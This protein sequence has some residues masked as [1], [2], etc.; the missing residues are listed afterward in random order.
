MELKNIFM[1]LFLALTLSLMG[2][3]AMASESIYIISHAGAGDPFWKVEFKGARAAANETGATLTI[4]APETPNDIA[5]E[6]ELLNS[7]IRTRPAGIAVTIPDADKFSDALKSARNKGIP[8][9][10][11]NVRPD[12]N[13]RVKNP[14]LAYIGMEEYLAGK[15]AG[16]HAFLSGKINKRVVVINHQTGHMGLEAR[17]KGICD[18][19]SSKEIIVDK[20][21]TNTDPRRLLK[22]TLEYLKKHSEVSAVFCLG[23]SSLHFIGKL[24]KKKKLDLYLCSFDISSDTLNFIKQGVADFTIDQQPYMQGYL[25]VNLLILAARFKMSPPDINTGVGIID[26][27]NVEAVENFAKQNIR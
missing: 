6:A 18:I 2:Y 16:Q 22:D 1:V 12:D 26:R 20:L 24:I 23:P 19:L 15:V 8:V 9:I 17:F 4:L 11:F 5:Q 14:Y 10:A 21:D 3:P 7:A 13:D 25:S 27:S